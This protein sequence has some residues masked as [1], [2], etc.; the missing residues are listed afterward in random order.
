MQF[1]FQSALA[2][3][4]EGICFIHIGGSPLQLCTISVSEFLELKHPVGDIAAR[5][6]ND[7]CDGLQLAPIL[8]CEESDCFACTSQHEV[9]NHL[10]DSGY[11]KG[12]VGTGLQLASVL[13]CDKSDCVAWKL[14]HALV[15]HLTNSYSKQGSEQWVSIGHHPPLECAWSTL[16]VIVA[17]SGMTW[18]G[19]LQTET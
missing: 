1:S 3:S 18:L 19:T 4:S 15:R 14:R 13:L 12:A 8:L 17:S 7:I 5:G 2:W 9:V 11:P 16:F 10:R 6:P